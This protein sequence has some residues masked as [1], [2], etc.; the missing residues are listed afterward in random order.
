MRCGEGRY[1]SD[2]FA[3][4]WSI[5]AETKEEED[6]I[7]HVDLSPEEAKS[8][9][10]GPT[11]PIGYFEDDPETEQLRLLGKLGIHTD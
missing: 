3:Q 7:P 11:H 1:I 9:K 10:G 6:K 8:M 4:R 2:W 5:E